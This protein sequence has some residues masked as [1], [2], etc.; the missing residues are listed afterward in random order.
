MCHVCSG[1]FGTLATLAGLSTLSQYDIERSG[2][3]VLGATHIH[4]LED[5]VPRSG[6]PVKSTIQEVIVTQSDVTCSR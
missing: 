6:K 1:T 5:R 3:F 4:V 2:L